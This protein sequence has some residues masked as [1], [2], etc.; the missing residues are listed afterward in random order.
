MSDNLC[1]QNRIQYPTN[2]KNCGAPLH[3]SRCEFCGTEYSVDV[4]YDNKVEIKVDGLGYA[5]TTQLIADISKEVQN[6]RKLNN[7]MW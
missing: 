4:A 5:T 3:G 7:Y 2:C 1:C 6:Q